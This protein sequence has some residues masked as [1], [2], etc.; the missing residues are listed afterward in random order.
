MLDISEQLISVEDLFLNVPDRQDLH[1]IERS[2]ERR[3]GG[4]AKEDH[5]V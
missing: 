5:Y 3:V 1:L 4:D 2:F